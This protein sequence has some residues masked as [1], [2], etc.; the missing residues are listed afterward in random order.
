[1]SAPCPRNAS[2]SRYTVQQADVQLLGQ[3]CT[4][5]GTAATLQLIQQPQQ[6]GGTTHG[7]MQV[8]ETMLQG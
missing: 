8:M 2:M 6:A 4:A 7:A 5:H 3:L 1:M